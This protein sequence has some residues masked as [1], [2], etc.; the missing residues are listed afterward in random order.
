[1][2]MF[3]C[4]LLLLVGPWSPLP[5]KFKSKTKITFF[6]CLEWEPDINSEFFVRAELHNHKDP[7]F[8]H[9]RCWIQL[10]K[11]WPC[12]NKEKALFKGLIIIRLIIN[13]IQFQI[14]L[15]SSTSRKKMI[16]KK[17]Y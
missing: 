16:S 4:Q 3:K 2:N 8:C 7:D 14:L 10:K 12:M 9:E 5:G 1:M 15:N 13:P 11:P 6:N 17:L